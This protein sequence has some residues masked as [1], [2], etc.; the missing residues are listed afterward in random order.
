MIE[1]PKMATVSVAT[2]ATK[3]MIWMACRLMSS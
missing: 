3:E 1:K 2:K